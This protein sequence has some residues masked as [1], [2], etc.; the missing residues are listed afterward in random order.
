[1]TEPTPAE[2][3]KIFS[4]AEL[5]YGAAEVE[6]AL[7]DMAVAISGT[8][9]KANPILLCI[10]TG[11]NLDWIRAPSIP[12]ENR[13][14]LILD[15]ILDKGVTLSAI[16]DACLKL[17]ADKIYSAVLVDKDTPRLGDIQQADFTGLRIPDRYVF[18]YGMDYRNYLRNVPGIYAVRGEG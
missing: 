10:M 2:I 16:R 1:M 12:L 6:Q 15:D 11:G 14:V 17:G 18:G 5:L 13:T 3:E 7:D 8:I 9:S 4:E